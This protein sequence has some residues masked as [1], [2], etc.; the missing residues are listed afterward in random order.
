MCD[1]LSQKRPLSQL[2]MG[3]EQ[4][5]S[6]LS[7]HSPST[8]CLPS[9][10]TGKCSFTCLL[11][12]HVRQWSHH[13][14]NTRKCCSFIWRQS[15][16]SGSTEPVLRSFGWNIKLQS[17]ISYRQ[18]FRGNFLTTGALVSCILPTQNFKWIGQYPLCSLRISSKNNTK[19]CHK[20]K[21]KKKLKI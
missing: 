7:F 5:F 17:W 14:K 8:H 4:D 19:K 11:P 3:P 21:H 16:L 13:K 10:D 15:S 1:T 2:Q 6:E 20:A 18:L 9:R 12:Y